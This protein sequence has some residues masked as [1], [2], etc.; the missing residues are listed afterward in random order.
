MLVSIFCSDST[1]NQKIPLIPNET[2]LQLRSRLGPAFLAAK[3]VY[4]GKLL[5]DSQNL[6]A[7]LKEVNSDSW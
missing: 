6:S 4:S 5:D 3:F 7:I 2:L 1:K